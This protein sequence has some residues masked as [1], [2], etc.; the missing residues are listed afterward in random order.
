MFIVVYNNKLAVMKFTN[1]ITD[2]LYEFVA[3]AYMNEV[4][5]KYKYIHVPEILFLQ[6]SHTFQAPTCICME[7]AR[8]TLVRDLEGLRLYVALAHIM[9]SIY[10][11]RKRRTSCIE[12][13]R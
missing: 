6:N 13:E 4:C 7:M 8:G 10:I 11:C 2:D 12:T 9:K 1:Q 5:R 3:Q